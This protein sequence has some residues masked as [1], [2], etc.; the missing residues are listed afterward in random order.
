MEKSC[1]CCDRRGNENEVEEKEG[2]YYCQSLA[3]I[4]SERTCVVRVGLER[5][6]DN[7]NHVES[8]PPA[9]A[10]SSHF[11]GASECA[12][13]REAAA[14]GLSGR[15]DDDGRDVVLGGRGRGGRA[16]TELLRRRSPR[17][18]ENEGEFHGGVVQKQISR[19]MLQATA[20]AASGRP[21]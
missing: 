9:V 12:V 13:V 10:R 2:E 4:S 14:E 16:R 5:I 18:P 8:P 19:E 1:C 21:P 17:G 7:Q 15:G 3:G 20:A 11:D 6:K